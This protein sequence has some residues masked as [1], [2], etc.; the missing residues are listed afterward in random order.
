MT[1][2]NRSIHIPNSN[3]GTDI[4][5]FLSPPSEQSVSSYS[6]FQFQFQFV[7]GLCDLYCGWM[8]VSYG[9]WGW[10]SIVRIFFSVSKV[11]RD[12][13][14]IHSVPFHA[15]IL[16][17]YISLDVYN[18]TLV[19]PYHILHQDKASE[20]SS[21]LAHPCQKASGENTTQQDPCSIE[22]PW[23]QCSMP[24]DNTFPITVF[25]CNA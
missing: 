24:R 7:W 2:D 15:F 20:M 12:L 19:I 3:I 16:P 22:C 10:F 25:C 11:F 6:D 18:I 5:S 17:T 1:S 9:G 4:I 14:R 13:W 23:T 8:G 21:K